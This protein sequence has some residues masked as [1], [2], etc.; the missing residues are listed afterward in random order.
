MHQDYTTTP[1]QNTRKVQDRMINNFRSYII[2]YLPF[3]S[4]MT[5]LSSIW[6]QGNHYFCYQEVN[7][8][9]NSS[10]FMDCNPANAVGI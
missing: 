7:G 6:T 10:D 8:N 1:D 4:G 3:A 9:N 2:S 5:P